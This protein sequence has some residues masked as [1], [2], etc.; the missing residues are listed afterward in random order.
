MDYYEDISIQLRREQEELPRDYTRQMATRNGDVLID[1]ILNFNIG[2]F[3]IF[4]DN[5]NK[6]I[7]DKI[8]ITKFGID[9]PATTSILYFDGNIVIYEVDGTRYPT[10]E[11]YTYYGYYIT[12]NKRNLYDNQIILDYNLIP[13]DGSREMTILSIWAGLK[14]QNAYLL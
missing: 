4:M 12:V 1:F 3:L 10:N 14:P 8:R 11:F 13:K 5:Y 2:R 6:S 7:P 9:G